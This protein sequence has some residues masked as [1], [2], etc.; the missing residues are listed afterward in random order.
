MSIDLEYIKR[1]IA[2]PRIMTEDTDHGDNDAYQHF[3][4]LAWDLLKANWPSVEAVANALIEHPKLDGK[5][6]EALVKTAPRR[7]R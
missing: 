4:G 6:V 2:G 1:T 3:A 5:R 7:N